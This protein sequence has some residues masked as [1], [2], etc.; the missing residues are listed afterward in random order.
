[1]GLLAEGLTYRAIADR[2]HLSVKTVDHHATAIRAKLV[3]ASRSE[4]VA[5]GRRLG[6]LS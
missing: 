1:L 4:A 3:V 2:L 6:I 5:V